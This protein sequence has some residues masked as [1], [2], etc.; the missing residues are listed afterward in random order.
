M[1]AESVPASKMREI[2]SILIDIHGQH[3]HQSLLSKK[4]HLEI[5]DDYAKEEIFDPKE[6]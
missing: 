6:S 3:E 2:A 1:N 4:K 5:L